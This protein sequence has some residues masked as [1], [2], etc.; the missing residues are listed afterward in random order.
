[1]KKIASITVLI[2]IMSHRLFAAGGA[3]SSTCVYKLFAPANTE[4]KKRVRSVF[5]GEA[6]VYAVGNF[7]LY[8]LWYKDYGTGKFHFFNDNKEWQYMDKIGHATVANILGYHGYRWLRWSGMDE[9][10]SILYGGGL[11]FVFL[12]TVEVFDGLSKG[13]GFSWGDVAANSCG[14][15][16]FILQQSL[17]HDTPLQLKYSYHTSSLTSIRPELL[18]SNLQ[19]RLL[20][21]YNGQTLWLSMNLRGISHWNKVPKW[22]CVSLGYSINGFVGAEDNVFEKDG[23]RYDY[24]TIKRYGQGFLSLD[25]DL[26]KV[27]T[28]RPWLNSLIHTFGIIKFPFPA[29]E[30]NPVEKFKGHILYF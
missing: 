26:T 6:S 24:S 10:R 12:S 18:G 4:N 16:L 23:I 5:I 25:V 27:H 19:E 14:S 1:M 13:W 29:L 2:V 3:D 15:A 22:L 28:K 7:G 20:K 8:H 21:D 30:Y 11:G 9:R 17:L